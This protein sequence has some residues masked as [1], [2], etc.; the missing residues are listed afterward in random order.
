MEAM[1]VFFSAREPANFDAKTAFAATFLKVAA[2]GCAFIT[3]LLAAVILSYQ[4]RAWILTGEWSSFPVSRV[5]ALAGLEE[6]PVNRAPTGIQM[7]FDWGRDLPASGLL[8]AVAA[9]LIGF[10]VFAASIEEQFGER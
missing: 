6:P 7:M 10:S 9:I 4:G 1:M 2:L 5:V 3:L 8:L